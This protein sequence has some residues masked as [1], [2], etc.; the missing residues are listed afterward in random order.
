M[1][2]NVIKQCMVNLHSVDL[3]DYIEAY[4]EIIKDGFSENFYPLAIKYIRI[5]LKT[6][7]V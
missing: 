4:K 1:D 7:M 2:K 3:H 5:R 6:I